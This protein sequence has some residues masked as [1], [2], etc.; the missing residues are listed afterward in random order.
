[1][2]TDMERHAMTLD[3]FIKLLRSHLAALQSSA[4]PEPH[5]ISNGPAIFLDAAETR[6]LLAEL[7]RLSPVAAA[8]TEL[9]QPATDRR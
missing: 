2:R 6:E 3:V 4:W 9:H 8:D 1:M 5:D 7:D